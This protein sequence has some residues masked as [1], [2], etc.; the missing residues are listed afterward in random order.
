MSFFDLSEIQLAIIESSPRCGK[1]KIISIDG[2]AGS[3]KTTLAAELSVALFST[4]GDVP[5]IHL[6]QLYEGWDGALDSKLFERIDSW[7]LTPIRNGLPPKYLEYDWHLGA[8][9][10]W[11]ELALIPILIICSV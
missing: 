11:I 8:Y 3:G 6:D 9:S 5:I 4:F 7:I 2:P 1:T 10:K